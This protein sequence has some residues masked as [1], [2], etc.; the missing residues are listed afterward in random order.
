MFDISFGKKY[1]KRKSLTKCI[2]LS[3]FFSPF[4]SLEREIILFYI[5]KRFSY[6]MLYLKIMMIDYK[7]ILKEILDF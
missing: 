5:I 4:F 3:P 6:D 2:V 7:D 1:N